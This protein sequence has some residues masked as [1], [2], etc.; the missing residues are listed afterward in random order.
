VKRV[1]IVTSTWQPAMIADMQR[2]RMMCHHLRDCGWEPEVLAPDLSCQPPQCIESESARCFDENAPFH[3]VAPSGAWVWDR[4]NSSSIAWR[5]LWPLMRVGDRLLRER[6]FDLVFFSTAHY[7]LAIAGCAWRRRYGTPFIIDL[8]DPWYA[9]PNPRTSRPAG[10]KFA[11]SERLGALSERFVLSRAAGVVSVSPD[12]LEAISRHYGAKCFDWQRTGRQLSE[13]F[14]FEV[15][16]GG[17]VPSASVGAQPP[18]GNKVGPKT[19]I[20]YCGAGGRVMRPAWQVLCAVLRDLPAAQIQGVEFILRGT[21]LH[22]RPGDCHEMQ[23]E[24]EREGLT[25]LVKEN[26][27]RVSYAESK[28]LTEQADGV[29]ILGVDDPSYMA[30]KLFAYLATGKPLLAVVRAGSVMLPFLRNTPG[31]TVLEFAADGATEKNAREQARDYLAAVR[32]RR[33]FDREDALSSHTA[34]TMTFRLAR[35]FDKCVEHR[36]PAV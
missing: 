18:V 6:R 23:E 32:M 8:H 24:A 13:P 4:L 33:V 22:Y 27:A 20:A 1:L 10:W 16:A 36:V 31:A 3:A 34:A 15:G 14:G 26:P 29:L 12:Y 11:V 30:S 25:D 2:A 35:F 7:L 5:T 21:A 17:E 9:R 28:Q 19:Q